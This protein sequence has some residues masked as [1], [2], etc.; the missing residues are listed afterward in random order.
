[1]FNLIILVKRAMSPI[2]SY[3]ANMVHRQIGDAAVEM[4]ANTIGEHEHDSSVHL[5]YECPASACVSQNS[6]NVEEHG[7]PSYQGKGN[8]EITHPRIQYS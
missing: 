3:H 7:Q 6:R 2:S 8:S 4:R 1:M 5:G